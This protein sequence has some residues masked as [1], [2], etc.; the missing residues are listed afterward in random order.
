MQLTYHRSK[1]PESQAVSEQLNY[2]LEQ[3]S[4]IF[5][6]TQ[7]YPESKNVNFTIPGVQSMISQHTKKQKNM[8]FRRIIN[9][10]EP[11]PNCHS[12]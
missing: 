10:L 12:C 6:R 11:T 5:I 3:S 8:T 1:T 9:Q 4:R 2:I 7:K